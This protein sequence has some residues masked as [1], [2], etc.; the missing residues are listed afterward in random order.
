MPQ[1]SSASP[2]LL[3][4]QE[5]IRYATAA[6]LATYEFLGRAETWTTVWTNQERETVT[7]RIYPKNVRGLLALSVDALAAGC[8]KLPGFGRSL[9]A[10]AKRLV[11]ISKRK[12]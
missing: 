8:R 11:K 12:A 7:L 9:A 1:F 3:L 5:T 4:M 2:G 6:G 10:R